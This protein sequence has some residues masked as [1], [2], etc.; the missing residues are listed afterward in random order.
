VGLLHIYIQLISLVGRIGLPIA[1]LL[2]DVIWLVFINAP[3]L[4]DTTP[5]QLPDAYDWS[6]SA[7]L[8]AMFACLQQRGWTITKEPLFGIA[9]AFGGPRAHKNDYW[10]RPNA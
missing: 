8:P 1:S 2:R 7:I 5:S 10:I 9:Q 6:M 4:P 3:A